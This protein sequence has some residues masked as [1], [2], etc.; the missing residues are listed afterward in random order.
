MCDR[1]RKPWQSST[2]WDKLQAQTQHGLTTGAL[3]PID[4]QYEI[5]S[6]GGV[7]FIVRI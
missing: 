2:L 5:V 1:T 7:A 6:D 3:K 4:T